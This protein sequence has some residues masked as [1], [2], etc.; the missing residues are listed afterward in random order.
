IVSK[1]FRTRSY[2]QIPTGM[3]LAFKNA[4]LFGLTHALGRRGTNYKTPLPSPS[5]DRF[6]AP[7]L[8]QISDENKIP[9]LLSETDSPSRDDY[10]ALLTRATND[11]VRDWNVKS[12][13]LSWPQGL[14]SL[15]GY[16]NSS[17]D[18]D[19][20]SFWVKNVYP[21]DRSRIAPS[22]Q[23]ALDGAAEHWSGEHRFR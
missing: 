6:V 22:I 9:R 19:K 5:I 16:E 2:E 20:I 14:H 8:P 18:C 17:G 13:T 1:I 3:E 21:G 23:E 4:S 10:L 12:G 15:L 11:A 7:H